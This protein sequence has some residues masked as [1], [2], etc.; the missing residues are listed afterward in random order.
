LF[1]AKEG[2][3]RRVNS[4]QME[5]YK[6]GKISFTELVRTTSHSKV[7]DVYN[8]L[9]RYE[10][11]FWVPPLEVFKN[12]YINSSSRYVL[13]I[14]SVILFC[15]LYEDI[16]YKVKD[17]FIISNYVKEYFNTLL[18]EE[19]HQS[20]ISLRITETEVVPIFY[21]EKQLKKRTEKIQSIIEWIENNCV[22]Q[23][24]KNKLDVLEAVKDNYAYYEGFYMSYFIDTLFLTNQ[25][26]TYLVSDDSFFY[27]F[28]FSTI[29]PVSTEYYI[30]L[31]GEED[32]AV[33][34]KLIEYNRVGLNL[35][36]KQ[37]I[38]EYEKSLILE[39][40]NSSFLKAL[41]SLDYFYSR[42]KDNFDEAILF[43]KYLYSLSMDISI[44]KRI[45]QSVL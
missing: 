21:S 32:S 39:G 43:L 27:K 13:D 19:K 1:G 5:S 45:S 24:A 8:N 41:R 44:K 16:N 33:F 30:R 37:L 17:K 26:N 38:F 4:T 40:S 42:T 11:F 29:Q 7:F 9:T 35:S 25:E 15:D 14:P 36:C 3:Q 22:V 6:Y 18:L 12:V 2:I 20:D 23:F 31:C 10:G 28:N 34:S